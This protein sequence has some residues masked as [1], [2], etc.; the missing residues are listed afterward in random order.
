MVLSTVMIA[1][2]GGLPKRSGSAKL[3]HRHAILAWRSGAA[4]RSKQTMW[5]EVLYKSLQKDDFNSLARRDD[6]NFPA[7]WS[8]V[9]ALTGEEVLGH[10]MAHVIQEPVARSDETVVQP[11]PKKHA[12]KLMYRVP[13]SNGS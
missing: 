6:K 1:V 5:E 9:T 2:P 3:G 8:P 13:L 7:W 12:K 10:G 4:R 11:P